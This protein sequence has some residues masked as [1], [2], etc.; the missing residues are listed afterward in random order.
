M[1]LSQ[2]ITYIPKLCP[3]RLEW[4]QNDFGPALSFVFV[5]PIEPT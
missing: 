1:I 2:C 3:T 4:T 5:Y